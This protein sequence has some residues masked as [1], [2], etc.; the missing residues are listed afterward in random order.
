MIFSE[1]YRSFLQAISKKCKEIGRDP[2][3]VT[4]IA[5]SKGQG[6]SAVLSAYESGCRDFGENR[7]QEAEEKINGAP[8][9]I[10][11]HFIGHL[12]KNKVRKVVGRYEVI[13][14]VDSF[15]L[16][17]KISEASGDVPSKVL[18]E[19]NVL[20]EKAKHGLSPQLWKECF[21]KVRELSGIEVRGLMTMA[22][23]TEDRQ[24]IR[25]CFRGL[26]ELRDDLGVA[27]LSMGMS[28]DWEIALEEGATHLRVGTAIFQ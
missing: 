1:G 9:D 12:Q 26:K 19:V 14:S 4:L 11:W 7:V 23:L 25:A 21:A 24:M 28:N 18:L 6:I 20:G 22:P 16:A 5:V 15:S 27:W 8:E 2:K 13:H 3:G 10:R 17:Q